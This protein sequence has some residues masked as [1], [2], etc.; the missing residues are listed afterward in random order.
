MFREAGLED[1]C[2]GAI[3]KVIGVG[4]RGCFSV[5]SMAENELL[6]VELIAAN[7]DLKDLRAAKA[8]TTLQLG[9]TLAKGKG[10]G[11]NPDLGAKA[12][13]ESIEEIKEVL[14]GCDMLF[15]A[16]GLGGGTGTG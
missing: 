10:V 6:G 9:P 15:I 1:E 12:A 13:E 5:N 8:K 14:Q 4:G 7:T 3:I 16:A 11:M 2:V